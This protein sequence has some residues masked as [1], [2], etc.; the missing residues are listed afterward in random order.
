MGSRWGQVVKGKPKDTRIRVKIKGFDCSQVV[1]KKK[2]HVNEEAGNGHAARAPAV[3]P[4][5]GYAQLRTLGQISAQA[6]DR[7]A[8]GAILKNDS[9]AIYIDGSVYGDEAGGKVAMIIPFDVPDDFI[10]SFHLDYSIISGTLKSG[11]ITDDWG[12]DYGPVTAQNS[13]QNASGVINVDRDGVG[14]VMMLAWVDDTEV[15]VSHTTS[16]S[17]L[18]VS[19]TSAPTL[20][21]PS[22]STTISHTTTTTASTSST[23]SNGG[24]RERAP[25]VFC[26]LSFLT[27]IF[28]PTI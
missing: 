9:N 24:L 18:A 16:L 13:G 28:F 7:R 10:G 14:N 21:L 2:R 6:L 3:G 25:I 8:D 27:C 12:E 19:A 15:T 11:L 1:D 5:T 23:H 22:E 26:A 20:S 17:S 4:L